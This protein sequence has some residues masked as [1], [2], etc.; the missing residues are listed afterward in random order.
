MV[1][2]FQRVLAFI[3]DHTPSNKVMMMMLV[4]VVVMMMMWCHLTSQIG[5]LPKEKG[6]GPFCD[7][8]DKAIQG[9]SYQKI[10]INL[11]IALLLGPKDESEVGG[12]LCV[13]VC[14]CVY[15]CVCVCVC[16]VCVCG[17]VWCGVVRLQCVR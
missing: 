9:T 1:E 8:W 7:A 12:C 5:V 10:D 2:L 3:K 17:V 15:V 11:P 6:D 16:G 14:A 13:Y 4:V